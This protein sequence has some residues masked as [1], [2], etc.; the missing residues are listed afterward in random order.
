MV[1]PGQNS[2]ITAVTNGTTSATAPQQASP[3]TAQPPQ[4]PQQPLDKAGEVA[5]YRKTVN[6]AS[7]RVSVDAANAQKARQRV[8]ET[9]AKAAKQPA[10]TLKLVNQTRPK[11]EEQAERAS[12]IVG[13]KA[14][15]VKGVGRGEETR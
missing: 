1:Q 6:D 9:K 12:K 14:Q 7:K 2:V 4:Q 11:L 15:R 13:E 8:E 10:I 5:Q 3:P